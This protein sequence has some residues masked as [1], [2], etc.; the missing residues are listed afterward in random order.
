MINYI[1]YLPSGRRRIEPS[2]TDQRTFGLPLE[3]FHETSQFDEITQLRGLV[4]TLQTQISE[5]YQRFEQSVQ[6]LQ[7][8]QNTIAT[9][10]A[11]INQVAV[12]PTPAPITPQTTT[13][14]TATKIKVNPPQEFTGK[15]EHTSHFLAQCR[16]VFQANPTW[17]ETEKSVYACSYLRGTAFTWYSNLAKDNK[18][19]TDFKDFE[20]QITTAF[21]ESDLVQKSK[22]QLEKLRQAKSCAVYTTEF[23]R[24]ITNIGYT[25]QQALIDM[26]QKGLKDSVKDLL[27][28]MP[29]RKTLLETQQDSIA[30]DERIFQRSQEQKSSSRP[31]YMPSMKTPSG[32]MPMELDAMNFKQTK[33]LTQEERDRRK[34]E[35]LCLY[36][37]KSDCPGAKDINACPGI[38][39]RNNQGKGSR[40]QTT[41]GLKK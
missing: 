11:T 31:T 19:F 2:M 17:S 27:L 6:A 20:T 4:Q 8:A 5:N 26:Y 36:D 21:G 15:R 16:L 9:L 37:G 29:V 34:R 22:M 41:L 13:T 24:L 28:T 33:K 3:E 38:I 40:P 14:T 23:N 12:P 18:F 1:F 39:K 35:G 30:C 25:D 7:A 32:P 10:T